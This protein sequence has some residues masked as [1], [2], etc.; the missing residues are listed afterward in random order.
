M[1]HGMKPEFWALCFMLE[2][3]AWGGLSDE[4][5]FCHSTDVLLSGGM[6]GICNAICR[7][8]YLRNRL[9]LMTQAQ[10]VPRARR[11]L[12]NKCR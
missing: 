6:V 3:S 10:A 5:S 2:D 7:R 11:H 9:L 8:T 12:T 1:I 4:H